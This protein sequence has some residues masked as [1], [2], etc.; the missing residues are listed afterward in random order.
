MNF[1]KTIVADISHKVACSIS[2]CCQ[3][4]VFRFLFPGKRFWKSQSSRSFCP[5]RTGGR[6]QCN[7]HSEQLC[8]LNWVYLQSL[9][10]SRYVLSTL[11]RESFNRNYILVSQFLFLR[12]PHKALDI[13]LIQSCHVSVDILWPFIW[14]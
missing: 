3:I 7:P 5:K 2:R 8:A 12:F 1:D 4:L 6:L 11:K 14:L 9:M 13:F 10:H